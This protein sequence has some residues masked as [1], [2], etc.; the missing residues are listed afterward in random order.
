MYKKSSAIQIIEAITELASG[1][2]PMS[3]GIARKVLEFFT[4]P[5]AGK[6]SIYTL[7]EREL[8]ILKYLVAGNSYKMI[9]V[10][11]HINSIYRK[12]TVN[13]KSEAVI[14]A[15]EERLV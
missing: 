3:G 1:R 8:D 14:K 4:H 9:T 2:S 12:L 6:E 11:S 7:S 13:S 10:R 15:L 5:E